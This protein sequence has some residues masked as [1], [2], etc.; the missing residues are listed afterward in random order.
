MFLWEIRKLSLLFGSLKSGALSLELCCCDSSKEHPQ[1][2]FLKFTCTN[3]SHQLSFWMLPLS[4]PVTLI[5]VKPSGSVSQIIQAFGVSVTICP[6]SLL[7]FSCAGDLLHC[8]LYLR[9]VAWDK[10]VMHLASP[11]R[12]TDIGI[13]LGKACYLC[14]RYVFISVS[15]FSFIFLFLSCSSLSSPLLSLLSLFSLSLEMTQND[16]EGLMCH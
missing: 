7:P 2:K 3:C 6:F 10:G 14:S 11:G 1:E 9:A 4:I 13:Q 8:M 15:S 5:F 12:P 16:P